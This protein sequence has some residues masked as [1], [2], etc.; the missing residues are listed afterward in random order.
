MTEV[1]KTAVPELGQV[2]YAWLAH[3]Y[4]P[5]TQKFDFKKSARNA[6]T[7]VSVQGALQSAYDYGAHCGVQV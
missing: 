7:L 1:D 2:K 5:R 4:V 6:P 3:A